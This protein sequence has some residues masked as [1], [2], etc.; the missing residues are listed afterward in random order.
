MT[1][2]IE[3]TNNASINQTDYLKLFMQELT[4]QD[5]LKPVDNKEFMAQMA[6][7]SNLQVAQ[8]S[9][10]LL[11]QL[12]GMTSASQALNLIGKEVR[13]K[14]SEDTG[15]VSKIIFSDNNPPQ[16]AVIMK[17]ANIENVMLGDI[18][19]VLSGESNV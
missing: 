10:E 12:L 19:E 4:Y 17:G 2:A 15:H 3:P 7:F 11:S 1:D 6:Q 13:I 14:T 9:Q 8:E 5:P 16:L 18:A